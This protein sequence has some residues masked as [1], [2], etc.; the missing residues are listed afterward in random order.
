LVP[1]R[2]WEDVSK[3]FILGLP[4]TQRKYDYVMVV[5]YIFLKMPHFVAYKKTSDASE[6][7]A[8]FFRE[9]VY[10]HGLSRTITLERHTIFL[11]HFWRTLWKR[12]SSKLLYNSSYHPQTDG[13]IDVVNQILRN[14]LR[15]LSGESS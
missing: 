2:P 1:K 14:L 7:V 3:D 10:L 8:L 5:V 9:V 12:L 15:S 11:G 4:R 13:K 6:V